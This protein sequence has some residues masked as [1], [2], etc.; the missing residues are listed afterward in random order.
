MLLVIV[1]PH[2]NHQ[3]V[4]I[5]VWL[6]SAAPNSIYSMSNRYHLVLWDTDFKPKGNYE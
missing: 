1:K 5:V 2:I 4:R 6:H 3:L